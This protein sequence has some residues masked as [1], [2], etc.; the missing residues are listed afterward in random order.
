MTMSGLGEEPVQVRTLG[1]TVKRVGLG[2][3]AVT[4]LT[5]VCFEAHLDFASVIPLYTLLVVSQSLTGDFRAS[6][7]VAV[8]SAACLDFFFTEPLFSWR[9]TH[10][11]NALALVAFL[12]T[13]LVITGL[14]SRVRQEARSSTVQKNRLDRLY[15]LS[16]QLL[17]LEPEAAMSE[18]FL[19]PF[20]RLFGVTEICVFEGDTAEFQIVGDTRSRLVDQT[21][22]AYIRGDDLYDLRSRMSVRCFRAG[23]K[24][25]GAIG[26]KDLNNAAEILGSLAALTAAFVE[27]KNAF[28]KATVASAAAQTAVYRSA[29][30]DALAHEFKTPLATILDAAGGLREAGPL[31][32]EQL[33]LTDT[34]E[35]EAARLGSLTSRLL[36]TAR[37]D[38]EE[39]RPRMELIDITSLIVQMAAQFSV[40]SPDRR[41]VVTNPRE[42]VDV[43]ADPEL[44]RLT[45]NQL[46]ENACKY[47]LPGSTVSIEIERLDD[48]IAV[49]V[50]NSGSS[51]PLDE[52]S[53]I[54][55]R[56]YRGAEAKRSTSGSG[57]GLYVARKIALAHGG[58]L[59]LEAELKSNDSVTFCLKIPCIKEE[60]NDA[61]TVK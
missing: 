36:R 26:F 58:A 37:L 9:V 52:R 23:G 6:A 24:M 7:T 31:A 39:I 1:E 25:T 30:L 2:S 47:S 54:F 4:L 19:E 61:V 43:Q 48:F 35:S 51:I 38:S 56:F 53:R 22:E 55:E 46:I 27:R 60:V 5:L 40:R 57:L 33:E 29:L 10:P 28:R 34:V 14:V 3:F 59:N 50:S 12:V 13:A 8:V 49:K 21:R 15:Q 44:L 42:T 41:I 32:F 16:Q 18:R 20:H 17:A 45:L 11:L